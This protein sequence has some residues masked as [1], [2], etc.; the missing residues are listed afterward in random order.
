MGVTGSDARA[1]V[2]MEMYTN[3]LR[4]ATEQGMSAEAASTFFSIVKSTFETSMEGCI[5]VDKAYAVF[6]TILLR[7][8]VQRPPYSV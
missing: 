7:H 1:K 4:F 8:S 5:A 2:L 3:N 6:K